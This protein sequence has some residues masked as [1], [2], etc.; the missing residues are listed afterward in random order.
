MKEELITFDTAKLAK[1]KGFN[2]IENIA[3]FYTSPRVKMY[4]LDE[5]GRS[6]P[7]KNIP[8]KAYKIGEYATAYIKNV[9]EAPTQS[10]LQKWLR[11]IHKIDIYIS[12][13]GF[14]YYPSINNVPPANQGNIKYVDRRWNLSNKEQF[15][16]F[17][18]YEQALEKGLQEALKLIK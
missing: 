15:S 14:G 7:I 18:I 3:Y 1:E 5:H 16:D 13:Y 9:I 8:K 2:N 11:E 17:Q 10:L 6:Y 12:G 4:R